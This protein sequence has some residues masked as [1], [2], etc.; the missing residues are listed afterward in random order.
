M[1]KIIWAVGV[2]LLL[3]LSPAIAVE[4]EELKEAEELINSKT[5]CSQL[6]DEQLEIIGEYYMEQM[7]PGKAHELMD[8]M[9]GL[10]EDSEAEEQF[11][12]NMAR[13]MYCSERTSKLGMMGYNGMMSGGMMNMMGGNT[14]NYG[15]MGNYGSF[16][17]FGF[18]NVLYLIL[19]VGLII[20]VY[21]WIIKLL[22][23]TSKKGKK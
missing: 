22:K 4:Q 14:M 11:H 12:V 6:S 1:K 18:L 20:L 23:N 5:A 8:R 21:L 15:M 19:L 10:E 17:Y 13:N 9:M 3:S 7:H 16:G 2:I